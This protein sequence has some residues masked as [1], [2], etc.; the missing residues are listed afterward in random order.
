LTVDLGAS[1][2]GDGEVLVGVEVIERAEQ[3]RARWVGETACERLG[4][5]IGPALPALNRLL[6]EAPWS[7]ATQQRD[8]HA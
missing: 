7:P 5:M 8:S 6:S 4:W 1:I 3:C 2:G